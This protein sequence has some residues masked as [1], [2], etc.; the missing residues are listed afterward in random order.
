[1]L[2]QAHLGCRSDTP[3]VP[4]FFPL[5]LIPNFLEVNF[6]ISNRAVT[7]RRFRARTKG[8][9]H[10]RNRGVEQN[11]NP[12]LGSHRIRR[13]HKLRT[14]TRR[15]ASRRPRR[16]IRCSARKRSIDQAET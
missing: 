14:Q 13:V 4:T 15:H 8:I 10:E 2:I 7:E 16:K 5:F 11:G 9:G 12:E 1:M 6:V 3:H